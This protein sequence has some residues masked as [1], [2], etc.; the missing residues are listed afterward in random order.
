MQVEAALAQLG[1][2]PANVRLTNASMPPVPECPGWPLPVTLPPGQKCAGYEFP[3]A[4]HAVLG[5]L[6][7]RKELYELM[8]AHEVRRRHGIRF[9]SVLYVR[10]D[11]MAVVPFLPWCF[12]ALHVSRHLH[13][14]IWWLPRNDAAAALV[15]VPDDYYRC[16][17]Q[18]VRSL[19][20]KHRDAA[21]DYQERHGAAD[22]IGP[23]TNV[24]LGADGF[25]P[26]NWMKVRAAKHGAQL[27]ADNSLGL[28][29]LVRPN[30]PNL[31]HRFDCKA[32]AQALAATAPQPVGCQSK[33]A[34]TSAPGCS[35]NYPAFSIPQLIIQQQGLNGNQRQRACASLTYANPF[36]RAMLVPAGG[37]TAVGEGHTLP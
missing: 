13:D 18:Y 31:P 1:A 8:A 24:M 21:L 34:T 5:Q 32:L 28:L 4:L 2:E 20:N 14:W 16:R 25:D 27:F 19:Y 22:R 23:F 12:H 37:T 7:S 36:N 17:S 30:L 3:C 6:W 29:A 33:R 15:E 10:P 9:E 11:L 26:E 35:A